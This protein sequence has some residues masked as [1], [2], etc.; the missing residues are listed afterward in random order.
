MKE[1]IEETLCISTQKNNYQLIS[2]I[3]NNDN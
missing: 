1:Y 3:S 2:L